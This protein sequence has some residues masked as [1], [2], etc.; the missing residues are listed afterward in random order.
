MVIG[1]TPNSNKVNGSQETKAK[2]PNRIAYFFTFLVCKYPSTKKYAIVGPVKRPIKCITCPNKDCIGTNAHAIWSIS[3]AT[4][5][6]YLI[7][8]LFK[9][10]PFIIF[11]RSYVR[12]YTIKW[13]TSTIMPNA[14]RYQPNSLK[15][16]FLI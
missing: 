12:H 1:N 7:W 16:C 15:S 14:I 4:I 9:D 2:N 8:F 5:T 10:I 11:L 3:I 6:K 13:Y